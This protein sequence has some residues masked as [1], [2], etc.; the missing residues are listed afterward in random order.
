MKN[1]RYVAI[2][3]TVFLLLF[4]CIILPIRIK[5]FLW[6]FVYN[7]VGLLGNVS[8]NVLLARFCVLPCM[9]PKFESLPG[10]TT[11]TVKAGPSCILT[12][13]EEFHALN[14]G[15]TYPR[16]NTEVVRSLHETS[17]PCSMTPLALR[18]LAVALTLR[19]HEKNPQPTFVRGYHCAN[20]SFFA[21]VSDY[22][23]CF[24]ATHIINVYNEYSIYSVKMNQHPQIV[25]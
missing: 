8:S 18:A 23:E 20:L 19:G 11:S 5:W 16:G 4:K 14:V 17:T 12:A 1:L 2:L 6:K 13:T 7:C 9:R 24:I 25:S 10:H 21:N 3:F 22:R 15:L